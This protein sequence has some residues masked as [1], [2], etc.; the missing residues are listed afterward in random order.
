MTIDAAFVALGLLAGGV[1]FA[2]LRW[3]TSFYARPGCIW[4]AAALQMARMVV[5]GGLL[6]L[7]AL[8]GALPLLLTAVGV[9]IARPIVMRLT[10]GGA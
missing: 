10:A 4:T 3:N 1:Y 7:A 5:L 9:M 6:Y 8:S 2:L